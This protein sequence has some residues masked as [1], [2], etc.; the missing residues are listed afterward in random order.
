MAKIMGRIGACMGLFIVLAWAALL[1]GYYG[2]VQWQKLQAER[3]T[4]HFLKAVQLE[5]YDDAVSLFGEPLRRESLQALQPLRLVEYSRIKA[6]FDD[7]CVCGGHAKLTFQ[8]DGPAVTVDA[9]FSLG[10]GLKSG[11]ICAGI[12]NEQ[13]LAIPQLGDWNKAICGSDSF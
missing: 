5:R 12:T 10:E 2:K 6:V 7:G 8:A 3:N 4:A 9:V 1:L 11:Q 13:R